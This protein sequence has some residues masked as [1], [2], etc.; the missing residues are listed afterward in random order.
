[1]LKLTRQILKNSGKRRMSSLQK[2]SRFKVVSRPLDVVFYSHLL[3]Y[4]LI[5]LITPLFCYSDIEAINTHNME[6][7]NEKI[8]LKKQLGEEKLKKIQ[9]RIDK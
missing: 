1:M 5:E 6:D 8:T 3:C 2:Y 7:D 9:V 4:G